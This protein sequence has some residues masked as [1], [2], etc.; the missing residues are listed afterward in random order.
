[1]YRVLALHRFCLSL[2]YWRFSLLTVFSLRVSRSLN[3]H[4]FLLIDEVNMILRNILRRFSLSWYCAFPPGLALCSSVSFF[5]FIVVSL[6]V[7]KHPILINILFSLYFQ[8]LLQMKNSPLA[9]FQQFLRCV[10]NF[11]VVRYF[12]FVLW[13]QIPSSGRNLSRF[14]SGNYL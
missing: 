8:Q 2:L 13:G 11:H 1:M 7:P 10:C 9:V 3:S 14:S 4:N 5:V 6:T 12:F